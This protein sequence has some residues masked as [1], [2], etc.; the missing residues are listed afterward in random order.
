M[1]FAFFV[2]ALV[3]ITNAFECDPAKI[4]YE[5]YSDDQCAKLNK[6]ATEQYQYV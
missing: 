1:K 2:A 4:E 5:I 6:E 3:I